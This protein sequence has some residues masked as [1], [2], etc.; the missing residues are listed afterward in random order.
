MICLLQN[1]VESKDRLR[2]GL[3]HYK[4]ERLDKAARA[5]GIMLDMT[6]ADMPQPE[7][8]KGKTPVLYCNPTTKEL[9]YEYVPRPLT[10]EELL[11]DV[12]AR[13]DTV[14]ALLEAQAARS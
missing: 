4:P 14:V 5:S 7:E 6:E 13:L 8:R 9:W 12:V 1:V 3:I 10:Q 11:A 2:V